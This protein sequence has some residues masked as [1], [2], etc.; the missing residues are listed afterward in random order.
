M[1]L[2]SSKLFRLQALS[3][4]IFTP[5]VVCCSKRST[6]SGGTEPGEGTKTCY[7]EKFRVLRALAVDPTDANLVYVGVEGRGVFKTT[8][9]GKTWQHL[10]P[11]KPNLELPLAW[12]RGA[13]IQL[14]AKCCPERQ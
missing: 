8:D 6:S 3:I 11:A 4:L 14:L 9:A 2:V 5:L 13:L 7:V 1:S 10:D 12:R